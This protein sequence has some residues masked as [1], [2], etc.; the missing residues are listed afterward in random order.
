MTQKDLFTDLADLVPDENFE[1]TPEFIIDML[2]RAWSELRRYRICREHPQRTDEEHLASS[3]TLEMAVHRVHEAQMEL[4]RMTNPRD[5]RITELEKLLRDAQADAVAARAAQKKATD[6]VTGLREELD[7]Y[8]TRAANFEQAANDLTARNLD[9]PEVREIVLRTVALL[10]GLRY[11]E[12]YEDK[13]DIN[14]QLVCSM[15]LQ[16]QRILRHCGAES[17]VRVTHGQ[18]EQILTE[19]YASIPD[20]EIAGLKAFAVFH[21]K[22]PVRQRA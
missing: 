22:L 7:S 2:D 4:K 6:Q 19:Y 9:R 5:A 18:A 14:R 21:P 17:D 12:Y 16:C 1:P 15:V 20:R 10:S 8:R 3:I 13:D 11:V